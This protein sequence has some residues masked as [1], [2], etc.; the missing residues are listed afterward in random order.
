MHPHCYDW[1]IFN[2]YTSS[3]SQCW[4]LCCCSKCNRIANECPF[5]RLRMCLLC[6]SVWVVV[7]IVLHWKMVVES[8]HNGH[9]DV[10]KMFWKW[11]AIK[12]Q[13]RYYLNWRPIER[14]AFN[15]FNKVIVHRRQKATSNAQ[16]CSNFFPNNKNSEFRFL[17]WISVKN[18]R[19]FIAILFPFCQLCWIGCAMNHWLVIIVGF[20]IVCRCPFRAFGFCLIVYGRYNS[21]RAQ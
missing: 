17:L 5:R 14:R 6:V 21:I 12:R 11:K 3:G 19:C 4:L 18:S 13:S 10:V 9:A 15:Y 16:K 2:I 1:C 20:G 8:S 7:A